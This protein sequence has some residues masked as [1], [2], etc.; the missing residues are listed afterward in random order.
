MSQLSIPALNKWT[1]VSPSA[2]VVAAM[3]HFC[4]IFPKVFRECFPVKPSGRCSSSEDEQDEAAQLGQ[5][6]DQTKQWR[7]LARKRQRK[8]G[9]YLSDEASSFR[10]LLWAVVT[11]PVMKIH[12]AFPDPRE[13]PESRSPN[14]GPYTTKGT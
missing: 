8:A 1:T 7:R 13:D 12:F 11:A 6:I 10:T 9:V 4:G 14:L 3:Q 2:T 5:P